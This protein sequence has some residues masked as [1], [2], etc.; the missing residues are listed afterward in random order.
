MA[1]A[2]LFHTPRPG[3][4]HQCYC[5]TT[6]TGSGREQTGKALE[7]NLK[8]SVLRIKNRKELTYEEAY[9]KDCYTV[10]A[11]PSGPDGGASRNGLDNL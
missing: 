3:S 7:V 4:S 8:I 6:G 5:G 11:T 10:A 1:G 9:V 2:S